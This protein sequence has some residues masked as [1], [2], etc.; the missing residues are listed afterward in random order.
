M[1]DQNLSHPAYF[2]GVPGNDGVRFVALESLAR[3]LQRVPGRGKLY[4]AFGLRFDNS[5]QAQSRWERFWD[6]ATREDDTAA[7]ALKTALSGCVDWTPGPNG[8]PPL[9]ELMPF[10]NDALELIDIGALRPE[11]E[12]MA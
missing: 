10:L 3:A 5:P 7:I 9:A 8:I 6:Y 1:D 4:E 11:K 12:P 2:V